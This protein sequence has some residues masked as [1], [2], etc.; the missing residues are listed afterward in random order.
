MNALKGACIFSWA[1]NS[2][3][4]IAF[5]QA[6]LVDTNICKRN[7][8]TVRQCIE[9]GTDLNTRKIHSLAQDI[10]TKRGPESLLGSAV[11]NNC[12]DA[13]RMLLENGADPNLYSKD[14]TPL[15]INLVILSETEEIGDEAQKEQARVPLREIRD[16]LLSHGAYCD[17][18]PAFR[19]RFIVDFREFLALPCERPIYVYCS[20]NRLTIVD[21]NSVQ[22]YDVPAI[23]VGS[24]R[25]NLESILASAIE[26]QG[27]MENAH[28]YIIGTHDVAISANTEYMNII[29]TTVFIVPDYISAD[30]KTITEL[31]MSHPDAN[32][33]DIMKLLDEVS[34]QGERMNPLSGYEAELLAI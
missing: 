17:G 28:A 30:A 5:A 14:L 13:V 10:Y 11:G 29:P 20:T 31:F 32:T 34:P 26:T 33:E 24:S 2:L 23:E 22:Q 4:G 1:I 25:I 16:L 19:R 3:I 15:L 12:V 18:A 6:W 8:E 7:I 21:Q 9:S 27:S